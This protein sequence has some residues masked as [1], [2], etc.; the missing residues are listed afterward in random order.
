MVMREIDMN[1]VSEP[2]ARRVPGRSRRDRIPPDVA[3]GQNRVLDFTQKLPVHDLLFLPRNV[4]EPSAVSLIRRS[5]GAITSI[6]AVKAGG[7][8]GCGTLV[9]DPGRRRRVGEIR[10]MVSSDGAARGQPGAVAGTLRWP[11]AG[12]EKLVV[13]MTVG[14]PTPSIFEGLGLRPGALRDHEGQ[15]QDPR[16]RGARANVPGRAQLEAYGLPGPCSAKYRRA[17]L[18]GKTPILAGHEFGDIAS[19]HRC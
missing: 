4:S 11:D 7:V 2:T 16:Y 1:G 17:V 9:R 6:L 13:Q 18:P 15:W 12:L 5:S 10:N 8:V 3:I 14:D 19:H